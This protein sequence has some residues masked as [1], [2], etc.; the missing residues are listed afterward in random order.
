MNLQLMS[1]Q[2]QANNRISLDLSAQLSKEKCLNYILHELF[3]VSKK[4]TENRKLDC[5]GI[6]IE[7]EMFVLQRPTQGSARPKVTS[8][9]EIE[10]IIENLAKK[11]GWELHN[12]EDSQGIP[13]LTRVVCSKG[14]CLT[15]E[16]GGQLEYSSKVNFSYSSLVSEISFIQNLLSETLNQHNMFLYQSGLNPW[17]DINEIGLQVSKY[18]YD[19]MDEYFSKIS[20]FGKRM[21]RQTC[22]VQICI[23]N[24]LDEKSVVD[25]FLM[26]QLLAPFA[27][28]IFAN[29]SVLESKLTPTRRFR[30]TAWRE[31]DPSRTGFPELNRAFESRTKKSCAEAYFNFLMKSKL[32]YYK[33][34]DQKFHE[35]PSD[36]TVEDWITSG[37]DGYYPREEDLNLLLSLLFPEVR[38]KGFLELRSLDCLPRQWQMV[39]VLFYIGIL[40]NKKSMDEAFQLLDPVKNLL[41]ELM[42]KSEEALFDEELCKISKGLVNIAQAGLDQLSY[43]DN[44]AKN[45]FSDFCKRYTLNGKTPGDDMISSLPGSL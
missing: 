26:S 31:I 9:L 24:G 18:R 42:Q 11:Q 21:M 20:P 32:I 10:K 44:D 40:F 38:V 37:I 34:K 8:L 27:A 7:L 3:K 43:I 5:E 39:P 4:P 25:R 13:R 6:A 28:A 36:F 19:L 14:G 23:D 1:N 33:G 12:E 17:H 2:P 30:G 45:L 16:P 22:T 29:S 35:A 41:A 15:F